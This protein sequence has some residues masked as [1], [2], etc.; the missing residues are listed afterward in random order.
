MSNETKD[1]LKSELLSFGITI[2]ATF[3]LAV[4]AAIGTDAEIQFTLAFWGG[5]LLAG[6]RACIKAIASGLPILL[7][8]IKEWV[9]NSK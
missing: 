1:L 9:D 5:V 4:S 7:M 8:A 3:F 6:M 2:L